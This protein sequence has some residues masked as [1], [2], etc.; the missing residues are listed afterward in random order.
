MPVNVIKKNVGSGMLLIAN[1]I[2][3]VL[4]L[5]KPGTKD[6]FGFTGMRKE[7]SLILKEQ[8]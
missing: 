7:K 1:F 4:V 8:E 3:L 6:A 2:T 5:V